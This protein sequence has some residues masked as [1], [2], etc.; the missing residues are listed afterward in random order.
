MLAGIES[1][2][3]NVAPIDADGATGQMRLDGQKASRHF[4][5]PAQYVK[6]TLQQG[7]MLP[8][9]DVLI[10]LQPIEFAAYRSSATPEGKSLVVASRTRYQ[11][12]KKRVVEF[13]L[14]VNG[15][16]TNESF[17]CDL[18]VTRDVYT[19]SAI[20][21]TSGS[22]EYRHITGHDEPQPCN[23]HCHFCHLVCDLKFFCNLQCDDHDDGSCAV[24]DGFAPSEIDVL[25]GSR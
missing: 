19:V 5:I 10:P 16:N 21:T 15:N 1:A 22:V 20:D 25:M 14:N 11:A 23:I 7:P 6:A 18:T 8:V 13:D 12:M 9:S 2:L 24:L 3:A 4:P 17:Y